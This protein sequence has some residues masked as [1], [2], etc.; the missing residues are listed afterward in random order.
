MNQTLEKY[1]RVSVGDDTYNLT[2][3]DKIQTTDITNLKAPNSGGYLLQNCN[4]LC[5]DKNGNGK[6][7]NFIKSTKTISPTGDSGAASLTTIGDKFMWIKTSSNNNSDKVFCSFKRTDITQI[8]NKTLYY[9]RF[10]S[11]ISNLRPMG[12]FRIQLFLGD[13]IWSTRYTIPKNDRS[14]DIWTDWTIINLDFTVQN[15]GVKLIY[16]QIDIAHADMCF[17]NITITHF[18]Y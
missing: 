7:S 6:I 2:K 4:I 11:S 14:S 16:D 13:I 3:Y 8:S 18:V 15:Y 12:R 5:N 1:L 9:N 10:S 17:S